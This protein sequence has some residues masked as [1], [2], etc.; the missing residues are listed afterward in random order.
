MGR[1]SK[2]RV[3][4]GMQGQRADTKGHLKGRTEIK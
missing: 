3:R 4:K 2:E 1:R